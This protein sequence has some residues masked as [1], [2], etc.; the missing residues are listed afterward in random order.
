MS[1]NEE[2]WSTWSRVMTF[3]GLTPRDCVAGALAEVIEPSD[4]LVDEVAGRY[5][6]AINVKLQP[7][8][9]RLVGDQFIGP[10]DTAERPDLHEVVSSVDF[11]SIANELMVASAKDE[12]VRALRGG[13]FVRERVEPP[14][15]R[16][17]DVLLS[18]LA[19][20]EAEIRP[21][22]DDPQGYDC[23]GCST[24]PGL[25]EDMRAVVLRHMQSE[26][27]TL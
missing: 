23:C 6:E 22:L 7:H 8:G 24:I 5:V 14:I 9:A 17:N 11:W 2:A 15:D 20:F 1:G 13:V 26:M 12:W 10:A 4:L 27:P 19:A 25:F 21:L 16:T 3:D 18:I